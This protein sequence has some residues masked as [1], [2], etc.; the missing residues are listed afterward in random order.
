MW[1]W[2]IL[3][4]VP[5]SFSRARAANVGLQGTICLKVEVKG[6]EKE[7]AFGWDNSGLR[8]RDVEGL[9]SGGGG[10]QPLHFGTEAQFR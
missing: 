9:E 5:A 10:L 7:K 4:V 8:E 1:L 2:I 6:K 3:K